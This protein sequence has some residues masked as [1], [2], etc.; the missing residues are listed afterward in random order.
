MNLPPLVARSSADV[1]PPEESSGDEVILPD[2]SRRVRR[3]KKRQV[4]EKNKPL[5]LFLIGWLS[6]VVIIFALFKTRNDVATDPDEGDGPVD[7]TATRDRQLIERYRGEIANLLKSYLA[8]TNLDEQVQYIDRSSEM[9]LKYDRFYRAHSFFQPTPPFA[10]LGSNVIEISKE[11]L[12]LALE[13]VWQDAEERKFGTVYNFD[14]QGWKLDWEAFAPYSTDAWARFQK[15]L[16]NSEGTFRLLVRKR[17]S[18]SENKRI[19]LSFYRAPDFDEDDDS[20]LKTESKEVELS[21]DSKL[22]K[23]FLGL[24]SRFEDGK[25]PFGSILPYFDPKGFMR[26]TAKLGWEDVEGSSDKQLV[27]KEIVEPSWFGESIREAYRAASAAEEAD[28]SDK[29]SIE[30][31]DLE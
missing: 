9:A 3:R 14:G 6:V 10:I 7:I 1:P 15:Q 19:D 29:E 30:N 20:F 26:I 11:P 13:F 28:K 23:Q 17:A 22:G 27:L 21:V 16:G 31:L 12:V 24:W 5:I 18:S 8:T 25:R 4:K 2:G